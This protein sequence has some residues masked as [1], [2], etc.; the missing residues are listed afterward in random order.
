MKQVTVDTS[1]RICNSGHHVARELK[2]MYISEVN[3][4]EGS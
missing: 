3:L 4:E 2:G 1:C